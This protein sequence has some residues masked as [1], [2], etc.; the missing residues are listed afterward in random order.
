MNLALGATLFLEVLGELDEHLVL[1]KLNGVTF[2]PQLRGL[3]QQFL[4]LALVSF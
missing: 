2:T 4:L 3:G 1:F